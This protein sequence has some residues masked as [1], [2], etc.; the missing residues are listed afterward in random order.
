MVLE[1]PLAELVGCPVWQ[2]IRP[3][4]C[5]PFGVCDTDFLASL[6]PRLGLTRMVDYPMRDWFQVILVLLSGM[7]GPCFEPPFAK[8]N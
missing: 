6:D 3:L 2:Q 4:E 8:H 7:P 1:V 5:G